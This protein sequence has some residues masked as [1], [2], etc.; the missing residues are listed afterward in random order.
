MASV[1]ERRVD[2][3]SS[4]AQVC[5]W[6][7]AS[8]R[9]YA[10]TPDQIDAFALSGTDLYV[11]AEGPSVSWVGSAG[12]LIGDATSRARFRQ[13]MQHADAVFHTIAPTGDVERM[14]L[15]WDLE[16]AQPVIG[17]SAA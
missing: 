9:L 2:P 10:L 6:R 1:A 14:T 16:S 3:E 7:G 5:N 8:G 17:L 13:A 4:F 11:V 12:D 15:A